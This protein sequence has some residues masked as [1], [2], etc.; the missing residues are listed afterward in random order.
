[1]KTLILYA[2]KYGATHEIAKKIGS[3]IDGSVIC[4]IKA[5]NLPPISD[6]E[7]IIIG[8]SLYAGSIRKEAKEF[9]TKNEAGFNGKIVGLF[10]S[11]MSEG[12]A[13]EAFKNNFPTSIL[14]N[15]KSKALLGGI[16]DPQK[17]GAFARFI[18]KVV[19]KQSGYQNNINDEKINTFIQNLK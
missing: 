8:S 18:M 2:T 10:L 19:T 14:E 3:R 1:M 13:D 11:G 6:Y 17:A 15:A 5:G 12:E 16:F 9:L 4:D 7:C